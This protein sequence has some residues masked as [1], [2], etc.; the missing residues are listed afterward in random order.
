[1]KHYTGEGKPTRSVGWSRDL[2]SQNVLDDLLDG[3]A[4]NIL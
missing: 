1:M 4:I 2:L 3:L